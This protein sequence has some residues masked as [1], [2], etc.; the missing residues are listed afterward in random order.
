[1]CKVKVKEVRV[2]RSGRRGRKSVGCSFLAP[3]SQAAA[4]LWDQGI[5]ERELG[6][7]A[8]YRAAAA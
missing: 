3:F 2:G 8:R 5:N 1:M 6:W 7:K 4:P